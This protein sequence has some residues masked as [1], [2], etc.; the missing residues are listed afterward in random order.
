MKKISSARQIGQVIRKKRTT[1][2]L[3][4]QQLADAS[5][6]SRGFINRIEKGTSTAVYPNKLLDVLSA[7]NLSLQIEDDG[8]S[9]ECDLPLSTG[10]SLPQPQIAKTID[11]TLFAT[12]PTLGNIAKTLIAD[13][14]QELPFT[15]LSQ[16]IQNLLL[17][18]KA[19]QIDL[20]LLI[21]HDD[22]QSSNPETAKDEE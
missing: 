10:A 20:S 18:K 17:Q 8:P 3:T 9:S 5:G 13:S 22:P 12:Q 16:Q 19:P 14:C 1:L 21:P 11:P 15:S 2:G 4:Q 6:V 7:L